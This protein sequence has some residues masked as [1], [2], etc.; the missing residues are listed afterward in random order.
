MQKKKKMWL[1]DADIQLTSD[2]PNYSLSWVSFHLFQVLFEN[3]NYTCWVSSL[4][5]QFHNLPLTTKLCVPKE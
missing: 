5:F 3:V 2:R 1:E 4:P